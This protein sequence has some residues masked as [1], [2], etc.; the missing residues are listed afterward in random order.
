MVKR[1]L[2]SLAIS[3]LL[4]GTA[5]AASIAQLISPVSLVLSSSGA[6]EVAALDGKP[7]LYCGLAAFD[8]WASPL[9]GQSVRSTPEQGMTVSVDARDVSLAGLMIRS[10][11][12]QPDELDDEA[13]A[14]ITEGRGGWACARAETP[15]VL[16][17]TSV[18]P[19]VLAG[20]ALNESAYNGRAWPWTLNVAGRGFFFR[21]RSDAYGAIRALIAAGRCDFDVGIMQINYCYHRWRFASPWDALAPAT[22]I[23]VAE[24]IL[25]ENYSRTHSIAKAIAY[26]HS[27]NP[28]PG[29]AYLA[30]FVRHLNQ[31][32]AGL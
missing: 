1:A 26:Y 8:S 12:L 28:V 4:S 21:S 2:S 32:N 14:A 30:R 5:H 31:I 19:K 27:A 22:N 11:W 24:A 13:Q 25:N 3:A 6:R 9:V 29:S 15:F 20:I 7:V 16:L 10:G 18:D 17:H 23:H